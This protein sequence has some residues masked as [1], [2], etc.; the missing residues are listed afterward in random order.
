MRSKPRPPG[1]LLHQPWAR[2]VAEGVFLVL[3]RSKTTRVRGRVAIVARGVDERALVDGHK[4]DSKTFPEP[5]LVGYVEI[6]GCQR[7]ARRHLGSELRRR[8]GKSF[9]Q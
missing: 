7:I 1:V 2:L 6:V 9:Q 4:P 8:F 5:A 3:L